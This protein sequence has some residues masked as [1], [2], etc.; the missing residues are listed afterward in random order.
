MTDDD[1]AE[2]IPRLPD[3]WDEPFGDVSQIPVLLVSRL[4]RTAVTVALSGDGGD[5]L[6]AGYNR[7]AWL[8]R[9]WRP[10]R[11]LPGSGLRRGPAPTL[12]RIPPG[13]VE[14][15]GRG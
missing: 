14:R 9:L 3:I 12:G 1:A 5:E 8:E 13:L 4:A 10:R 6:F 7:H 2:V 11:P 15:A